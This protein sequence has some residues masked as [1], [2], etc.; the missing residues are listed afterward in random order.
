M[1]FCRCIE[2]DGSWIIISPEQSSKTGVKA[3]L[4]LTSSRM[5]HPSVV[6]VKDVKGNAKK[7]SDDLAALLSPADFGMTV[8]YASGMKMWDTIRN[9]SLSSKFRSGKLLVVISAHSNDLE[10]L[11]D[12]LEDYQMTGILSFLLC[13]GM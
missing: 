8:M 2:E 11:N 7:V 9:A 10:H 4:A 12:F 3:G 6:V 5:G 1:Q 13:C